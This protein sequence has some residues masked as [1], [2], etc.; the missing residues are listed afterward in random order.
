MLRR[1]ALETIATIAQ[2]LPTTLKPYKQDLI[3]QIQEYKF[4]KIKLVREASLETLR[5]LEFVNE[6]G[7]IQVKV[8]NN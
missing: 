1:T 7:A 4:D 5:K 2:K 3:Q 6:E 8:R